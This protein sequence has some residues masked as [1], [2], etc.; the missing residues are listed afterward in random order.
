MINLITDNQSQIESLCQR[1]HV[2]R[3]EVFGSAAVGNFDPVQS[4]LDFLVTFEPLEPGALAD[5]YFGLLAGLRVLFGRHVDLLTMKA[6]RNPYL[7]QGIEDTRELLY[8]G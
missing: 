3:L 8:G 2:Q 1:F 5:A 6:V 7:R 4:D